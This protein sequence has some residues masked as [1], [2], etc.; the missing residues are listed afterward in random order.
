LVEILTDLNPSA[1]A[2]AMGYRVGVLQSSE[3]G[4]LVYRRLGFEKVCAMEHF[5]YYFTEE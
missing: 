5:S 4:F 1:L 3:M 2:Q